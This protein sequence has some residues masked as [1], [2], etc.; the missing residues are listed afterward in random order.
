MTMKPLAMR[1]SWVSLRWSSDLRSAPE[2]GIPV[3][4]AW[5]TVRWR[6]APLLS[7]ELREQ[8]ERRAAAVADPVIGPRLDSYYVHF[9]RT[10][11]EKG[12]GYGHVFVNGRNGD[13]VG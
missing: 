9:Y 3:E 10:T 1:P 7:K 2:V 5:E 6:S 13:V 4:K 11:K 12:T 8:P